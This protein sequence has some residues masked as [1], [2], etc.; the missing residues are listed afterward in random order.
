MTNVLKIVIN[1]YGTYDVILNGV[2]IGTVK[3]E[4]DWENV[5]KNWEVIE[6]K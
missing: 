6:I 3:K 2:Y 1:T 4:K 5:F